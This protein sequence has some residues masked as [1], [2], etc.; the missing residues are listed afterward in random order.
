MNIGNIN[1]TTEKLKFLMNIKH[2][3]NIRLK[4]A[5]VNIFAFFSN[6]KIILVISIECPTSDMKGMGGLKY[7]RFVA[8]PIGG[9][10]FVNLSEAPF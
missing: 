9:L 5:C 7:N 6:G 1:P 10:F 4:S 3:S 8:W 2:W